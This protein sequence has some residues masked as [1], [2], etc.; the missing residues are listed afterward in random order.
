MKAFRES[1]FRR[2]RG[3][4]DKTSYRLCRSRTFCGKFAAFK[5]TVTLRPQVCSSTAAIN[6]FVDANAWGRFATVVK[7]DFAA[8]KLI[9]DF[10]AAKAK[11]TRRSVH[12]QLQTCTFQCTFAATN[13]YFSAYVCSYKRVLFSVRLRM[14]TCKFYATNLV[15]FS[16]RLQLQTYTFQRTF[17][18]TDVYFLASVCSCTYV[19]CSNN[20][21]LRLQLPNCGSCRQ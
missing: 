12:L 8:S 9:P 17:T 1:F 20:K 7:C 13:L 11:L 6:L 2:G 18:A 21:N 3:R 14:Q 5:V 19:F 10:G 4:S 15:I 16:V